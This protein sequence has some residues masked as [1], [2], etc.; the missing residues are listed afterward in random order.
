MLERNTVFLRRES[1]RSLWPKTCP[2]ECRHRGRCASPQQHFPETTSWQR[3]PL[4]AT[5]V[6]NP[7]PAVL[8]WVPACRPGWRMGWTVI[9]IPLCV[10]LTD[11]LLPSLRRNA[12]ISRLAVGSIRPD[13]PWKIIYVVVRKFSHRVIEGQRKMSEEH[14]PWNHSQVSLP[15]D[16]CSTVP[17]QTLHTHWG[18]TSC[19]SELHRGFQPD[20]T[21]CWV[22][23]PLCGPQQYLHT[24][25]ENRNFHERIISLL[26]WWIS[27]GQSDSSRTLDVTQS[28]V[29]YGWSKRGVNG[30]NDANWNSYRHDRLLLL[31]DF[32]KYFE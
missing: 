13:F 6:L 12:K 25:T 26:Q 15:A 3:Q 1:C 10:L 32:N 20:C 23:S 7:S 19:T 27:A 2:E 4:S 30:I 24:Y 5:A 21:G 8:V 17:S 31:T 28:Y 16:T 9:V 22:P 18:S 11:F 29:K 14:R